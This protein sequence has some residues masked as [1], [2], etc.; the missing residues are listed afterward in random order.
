[1]R[2]DERVRFI[3][4]D[5]TNLEADNL[6]VFEVKKTSAESRIAILEARKDDIMSELLELYKEVGDD[7]QADLIRRAML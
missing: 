3:D 5:R 1:L 4:G 6:E 2:S 7:R